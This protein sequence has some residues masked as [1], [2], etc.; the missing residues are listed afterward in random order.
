QDNGGTTNG[1]VDTS[2]TQSFVIT[3]NAVNDA[4]SFVKGADQTR[5]ENSGPQSVPNWATAISAGPANESGQVVSFEIVSSSNAALFA[6]GGA[7]AVSGTGTLTYTSATDV[8][9]VAT[10]EVRA[11][12]D[13]GGS[14]ASPSQTFTITITDGAPGNVPAIAADDAA[15]VLEDA[16]A[17]TI[18]VLGNDA[19]ADGDAFIV[20]DVTQGANGTTAIGPAGTNVTFTPAANFC[21]TTSFGYTI[22]GGDTATVTVTVTCVNDAPVAADASGT[23]VAGRAAG[24]AVLT[25]TATDVDGPALTYAITGGN[26]GGAFAINPATGAITV[27]IP[28]AVTAGTF[29]LTI[30]VSDAGAPLQSDTASVTITVTPSVDAIFSNGYEN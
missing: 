2:A 25:V 12:D 21:G 19:D 7:P 1:G 20:T 22:T 16:A 6:A 26:T 27:A 18:A 13:G 8:F 24:T 23:V 17:A 3:V 29:N 28:N 15:T 9:G 30:T 11:I 4:P 5:E 14:N 10:I